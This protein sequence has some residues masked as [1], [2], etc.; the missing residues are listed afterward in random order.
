MKHSVPHDLD[1]DLARKAT[2]KALDSYAARF[3]NY[4][5]TVNWLNDDDAEISFAAKG[6]KL[7]GI[8]QVCDSK[9][10][11]DLDVPFLLRA[12]QKKAIKIID[13]E[14]REW[15]GKAKAGEL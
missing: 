5:A 1:K 10:D 6:I 8:F 3:S 4:N 14:I 2:Q 13:E 7:K 15:V 12:F 9:V 11:M